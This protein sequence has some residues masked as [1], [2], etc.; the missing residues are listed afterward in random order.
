MIVVGGSKLPITTQLLLS[1]AD[2]LDLRSFVTVRGLMVAIYIVSIRGCPKILP[3]FKN[4]N[5]FNKNREIEFSTKMKF[6]YCDNN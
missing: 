4:L 6:K 3:Y 5:D 2:L 1:R